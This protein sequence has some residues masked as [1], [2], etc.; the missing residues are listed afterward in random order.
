MFSEKLNFLME[1]ADV[2]NSDLASAVSMD[3]SHISRLRRGNRRLPKNQTYV[4]AMSRYFAKHI[5]DPFRRRIVADALHFP[6]EWPKSTDT[7]AELICRWLTADDNVHD[8][9]IDRFLFGFAN[10][11]NSGLPA[12]EPSDKSVIFERSEYCYYG[13]AGKQA[14]VIRFLTEILNESSPQTLLLFS[15]EE[16]SWLYGDPAFSREWARLLK[17][18]LQK[19]NRIKIIHT[20]SRDA[21]EM[22]EA[23]TKWVPVYMTGAIESY[24]YPKLR[25]GLF[26]RTMF[27]APKTAAI[28]SSSVKQNVSEMLN[29]YI[30]VPNGIKALVIEYERYLSLCRPLI[31]VMNTASSER[32]FRELYDFNSVSAHGIILSAVPS[33]MTM[34]ENVV[35]AFAK[36]APM[37]K[38]V[39]EKVS[40]SFNIM[41][42]SNELFEIIMPPQ[43]EDTESG[44]VSLPMN[45]FYFAE[46]L[47]YTQ[48]QYKEHLIN[49]LKLTKENP[50]YHVAVSTNVQRD[51]MIYAKEDTGVIMA[52][53]C[54]PTVVFT[55]REP[56][57]TSAFWSFLY[58]QASYM[59]S[60]KSTKAANSLE[61]L[62][63]TI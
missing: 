27:I 45:D 4:M 46:N 18:V 54:S 61:S 22:M 44:C 26:Q 7:V 59:Q 47:C 20:L 37:I 36:K 38:K 23:V 10:S 55:M 14:A 51:I 63:N 33:L 24:Y 11:A 8:T 62:I 25:D 35:N 2:K 41:T 28:V 19:G 13:T 29:L 56:N 9:K 58:D 17:G 34:P 6:V 49:M 5:N 21:N 42:Q 32:F 30:V 43:K 31:D 53:S 57:I 52:K 48:K 60:S 40:K 1:I 3:A 12:S 15:D 50:N 39:W 16:M